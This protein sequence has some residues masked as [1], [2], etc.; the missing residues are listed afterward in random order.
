MEWR[1]A[2]Q[3]SRMSPHQHQS[4]AS[5]SCW[6][7]KMQRSSRRSSSS[8][9][10][11]T[12]CMW[13][14]QT[15][16]PPSHTVRLCWCGAQRTSILHPHTVSVPDSEYRSPC[17]GWSSTGRILWGPSSWWQERSWRS[18]AWTH[19]RWL[20]T[21]KLEMFVNTGLSKSYDSSTSCSSYSPLTIWRIVLLWPC[22]L[23]PLEALKSVFSG[24]FWTKTIPSLQRCCN[25]GLARPSDGYLKDSVKCAAC[26]CR[27]HP[28]RYALQ[29][30]LIKQTKQDA[31][32]MLKLLL[33]SCPE[34]EYDVSNSL[35][36]QIQLKMF[37]MNL[38]LS[39]KYSGKLYIWQRY[40]KNEAQHD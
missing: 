18:P 20:L 23:W 16:L 32:L 30:R 4:I 1:S 33:S 2:A 7:R 26:T 22:S 28:G 9:R 15:W 25:H 13:V 39:R 37:R 24:S 5:T 6:C 40:K 19:R 21:F 38:F 17:F 12:L 10:W 35:F 29:I 27:P 3:C 34:W 14:T 36:Y 31:W 8:G 11:N